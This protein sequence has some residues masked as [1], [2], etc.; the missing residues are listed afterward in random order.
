MVRLSSQQGC[1]FKIWQFLLLLWEIVN[2]F[3]VSLF[4]GNPRDARKADATP[5]RTSSYRPGGGGGVM[6]YAQQLLNFL[7]SAT[8][9]IPGAAPP[10][11]S[12]NQPTQ[13][14]ERSPDEFFISTPPNPPSPPPPLPLQESM[15]AMRP[16]RE[17]HLSPPLEA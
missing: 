4:R 13:G 14:G 17:A 10:Q 7:Q 16:A 6:S 1:L 15:L 11:T 3:V 2:L 8:S 5:F 9:P 12:P